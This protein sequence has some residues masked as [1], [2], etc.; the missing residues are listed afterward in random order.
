MNDELI[1]SRGKLK[2]LRNE[3]NILENL[4]LTREENIINFETEVKNFM[5]IKSNNIFF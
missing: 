1:E 2:N 5:K 3:I 4:L